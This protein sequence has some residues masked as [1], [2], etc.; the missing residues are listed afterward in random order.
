MFKEIYEALTQRDS[1]GLPAVLPMEV[2]L[3]IRQHKYETDCKERG[4]TPKVN[5]YGKTLE[6]VSL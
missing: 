1:L 4:E 3:A 6:K 2:E 5:L